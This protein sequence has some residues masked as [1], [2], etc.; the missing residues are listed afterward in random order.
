M[1]GEKTVNENTAKITNTEE[2][3]NAD[4]IMLLD[5]GKIEAA[6]THKELLETSEKYRSLYETEMLDDKK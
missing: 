6:G 1:K 5:N 4:K 2:V 3:V